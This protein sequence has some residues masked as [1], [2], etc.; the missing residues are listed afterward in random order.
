MFWRIEMTTLKLRVGKKYLVSEPDGFPLPSIY[1]GRYGCPGQHGRF[2]VFTFASAPDSGWYVDDSLEGVEPYSKERDAEMQE[3][4]ETYLA[5]L[6]EGKD[7]E[8][9]KYFQSLKVTV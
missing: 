7:D 3:Q 8:A 6:D 2:H 1:R 5:L 4:A 9:E